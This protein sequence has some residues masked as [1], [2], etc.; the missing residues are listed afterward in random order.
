MKKTHQKHVEEETSA[1]NEGSKILFTCTY[2]NEDEAKLVFSRIGV[3]GDSQTFT[4]V[5]QDLL[6]HFHLNRKYKLEVSLKTLHP[7]RIEIEMDEDD[8]YVNDTHIGQRM[9][10][11]KCN[12]GDIVYDGDR[13]LEV[14]ELISNHEMKLVELNT[15]NYITIGC[16][17]PVTLIARKHHCKDSDFV[18]EPCFICG[19]VC[20]FDRRHRPFVCNIDKAKLYKYEALIKMNQDQC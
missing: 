16:A 7:E 3:P 4:S 12:P 8:D 6:K 14:L 9:M 2:K 18:R 13:Y 11:S 5:P 1:K 15:T 17:V 20:Y 19:V 10:V